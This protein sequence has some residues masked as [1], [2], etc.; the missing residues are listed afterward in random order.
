V[1]YFI[2]AGETGPVKIGYSREPQARLTMLQTS[3]YER[4]TMLA[5]VEGGFALE[6]ALHKHFEER[7][8]T[9]EWF[10]ITDSEVGEIIWEILTSEFTYDLLP[11]NK[12]EATENQSEKARQFIIEFLDEIND[13]IS[14]SELEETV[15]AAGICKR[16]V[17]GTRAILCREGKIQK[18]KTTENNISEWQWRSNTDEKEVA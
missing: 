13:W 17:M 8:R 16:T 14:G 15:I 5:T 3:H 7:R 4:L 1:I 6:R 2:K 12:S 10:I 9:G 11:V 18:R